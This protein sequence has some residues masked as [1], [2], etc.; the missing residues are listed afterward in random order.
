M[1]EKF[2]AAIDIG[3]NSFHLIVVKA[4]ESGNFEIVDRVREV[5]RLSE[6][7]VGDIK[8]INPEAMERGITALQN[9]KG[10]AESHKAEVIAVATS[11]VRESLNREDF[12]EQ[13][14]ERCGIDISIISGNEEA[15]LIYMGIAKALPIYDKRALCIDIGGGSTEFVIAEKGRILF[16]ISM[17]IGAVRLS[18][19]FFP[20]YITDEESIKYCRKWIKGEIYTA[21]KE[22][23][24]HGFDICV[25]SSGTIQSAG[26]MINSNREDMPADF[27][28]LNNFE[29]TSEELNLIKKDIL[30]K[31]TPEKRKK[32]KGLEEKRAEIIPAGILIL[33]TI[34][35][36]LD[37]KSMII[38][39]YA[40]R[41]G[42]IFNAL[43]DYFGSSRGGEKHDVRFNS[44]THLA[45]IS[46]FDREHCRHVADL[47][48]VLFDELKKLHN[49]PDIYK[50][51]LEAAALLHDI[52]YHISYEKH[53]KHSFYIIR[54]SGLLGF[55]DME[56][57]MIA[58]IARYHRKSHPKPGH[59][60][61]NSMPSG[62]QEKVKILAS[63]L[64]VADALDR[65][66]SGFVDELTISEKDSY[67]VMSINTKSD[68]IDIELWSL[69]RRKALFEEVFG[70]ELR[71]DI[72]GTE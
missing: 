52:G 28:I 43:T 22:I 30:A 40:L 24:K 66:H 55:D 32:I 49:L 58:N 9:F 8:H 64:R 62:Q 51:Y 54:N 27:K 65:T 39:E 53:H 69:D 2:L 3:T 44:I 17:K 37:I 50:E 72:N 11:A 71:V 25:G 57:L 41:E 61:F 5:I 20:D 67:I 68:N 48:L 6:G 34:F 16:S 45:E 60:E 63:I 14:R 36:E 13:V 29:F 59:T 4:S 21:I 35:K 56:I 33:Y 18:Q 46:N 10:I 19:K 26:L 47:S 15:R 42:I 1:A 31:S 7:N 12:R 38:S 70:R 23:K